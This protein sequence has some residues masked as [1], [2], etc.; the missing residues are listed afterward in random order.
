MREFVLLAALF[1]GLSLSLPAPATSQEPIS[2]QCGTGVHA[3]EASGLVWF[4]EGDLFCPLLADPKAER[5]FFSFLQG[6]FATLTDA[7]DETDLGSMGLGD[8]F[9]ILRRGGGTPGDGWQLGVTGAIFAQFD[10][11]TPSI[12]LIN[13]DYLAG[14]GPSW[15]FSGHSGRLIVFHQSS[16]LGD[17]YI[18]RS[19]LQRQ[20]LAFEGV[21]LVVSQELG[22]IRFYGG[23]QYLFRRDPETLEDLVAHGGGE[24][25]IGDVR[26][27]RLVGAVDVKSSEE[28]DWD[29]AVSARAGIEIAVWNQDDHPPRL[30]DVV[31]EYYSGPSPYGQFFQEEIEYLG[32][33][34]HFY[35]R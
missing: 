14:V 24:V 19:D 27:V 34:I 16:H 15:R 22:P 21:D 9:V 25:R 26:G 12:D 8:R 29:P 35:L 13:A 3:A 20:N 23:G 31:A 10:F 4:P 7:T 5:S 18:L 32:V 28:Q 2:F 33:G 1:F 11:G 17:E 6:E 30:F